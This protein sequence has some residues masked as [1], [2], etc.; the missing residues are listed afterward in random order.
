[1]PVSLTNCYYLNINFGPVWSNPGCMAIWLLILKM[2][3][4]ILLPLFLINFFFLLVEYRVFHSLFYT[5][6]HLL[7]RLLIFH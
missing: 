2:T 5:D 6:I 7:C 4:M 1:M 3:D